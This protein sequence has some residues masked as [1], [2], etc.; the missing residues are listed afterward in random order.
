MGSRGDM[1]HF[2]VAIQQAIRTQKKVQQQSGDREKMT[3]RQSEKPAPPSVTVSN[4]ESAQRR[5]PFWKGW[6]SWKK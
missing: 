1:I 3:P 6:F 4:A 2:I 5:K